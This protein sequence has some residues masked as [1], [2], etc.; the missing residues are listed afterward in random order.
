MPSDPSPNS[1]LGGNEH[2]QPTSDTPEVDAVS[3]QLMP[4]I[5][6]MNGNNASEI[7]RQILTGIFSKAHS[8]E[9]R[10]HAA[11]AER[12]TARSALAKADERRTEAAAM[13]KQ[14]IAELAALR[15]DKALVDKLES[16]V[17][18]NREGEKELHFDFNATSLRSAMT[19]GAQ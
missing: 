7:M 15:E 8:L 13:L 4:I 3:V 18:T 12:D 5:D 16:M 19:G 14:V 11:E 2:A 1:M 10:L 9:R 17:F 6:L